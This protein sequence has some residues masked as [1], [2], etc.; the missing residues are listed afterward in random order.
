MKGAIRVMELSGKLFNNQFQILQGINMTEG[1][2]QLTYVRDMAYISPW[3]T[4][5]DHSKL[6]RIYDILQIKDLDD[7]FKEIVVNNAKDKE[8]LLSSENRIML[9]VKLAA[10]KEIKLTGAAIRIAGRF[11]DEGLFLLESGDSII[12]EFIDGTYEFTAIN[13]KGQMHLVQMY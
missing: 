6:L 11:I 10:I 8:N 5:K 7:G 9:L 4:G 1:I 13:L 3:N 2:N 12:I